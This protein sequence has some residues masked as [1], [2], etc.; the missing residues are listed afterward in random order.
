MADRA[1]PVIYAKSVEETAL[2]YESLGFERHFQL[3]SDGPPGYV[4]LRRAL[5]ECAVVARAWPEDQ[6]GLE[7]GTQPRFEMF[8]YVDD[9]EAVFRDVVASGAKAIREPEVMPWGERVG[10]VLDPEGNP[11]SLAAESK[12]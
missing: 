6:Y 5:Y 1:F 3:P 8:I 9:L 11:V 2:F 4:G 12:S 10:F 7:M